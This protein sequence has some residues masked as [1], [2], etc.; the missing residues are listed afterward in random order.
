MQRL[1]ALEGAPA[2]SP[3]VLLARARAALE[4]GQLDRVDDAVRALLAD[5]PWEWRAVWMSGLV[6]LARRQTAEAQSAFNAVYGQVPGELAPK[7]A[8][9]FACETGGDTDVAESLYVVCART[10]ANYIAPAAFGLARIRSGRGDVAGA[11]RALDL[12]PVTS[13][14]F[15]QARRRRA[16]LLAGSGGGLPSLAAALDSIESLT[17]DP[18]DRS[19]VPRR[20]AQRGAGSGASRTAPTPRVLIAGRPAA[21]PALRDGLEA[22]YR[23]L[24]GHASSREERVHLVDQANAVRRWTLR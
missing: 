20:G 16:G 22:A 11:V 10:D 7:L 23:D 2:T 8:L 9:A 19:A 13:R 15:T 24:A 18:V 14:A 12:V 3:E 6:A 1:A 21:E 17:I 5:D 4:A